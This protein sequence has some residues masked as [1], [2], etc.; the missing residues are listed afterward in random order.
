MKSFGTSVLSN[1]TE[2]SARKRTR[3]FKQF[4]YVGQGLVRGLSTRTGLSS[5][6]NLI[7]KDALNSV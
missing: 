7:D 1:L 3:E 5:M 4:L 6:L 2:G